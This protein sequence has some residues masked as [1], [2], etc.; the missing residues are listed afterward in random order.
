ME[1]N[2]TLKDWGLGAIPAP[3]INR[4][5][6]RWA[7]PQGDWVKLN[8]DGACRGNPGPAGIGV[9]IRNSSGILLG[10][11]YGS[12]G[13]ATN[14][15]AE[16]RALAAG[17]DLCIQRGLDKI[18]F[19]GESQII[20]N[21]VTKS[22]FPNWKLGKWVHHINKSLESINSFEFKHNY[23]EGN[24]VVDLLANMGIE[25]NIGTIVFSNE[26]ADTM[27]LDTILSER[28]ERQRTGIR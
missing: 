14:N 19:E 11:L 15:E 17:L 16:I 26:D 25:K 24:K 28:P 2:W 1:S 9:V 3:K 8:F 13:L 5:L 27:V 7:P 10:G 21:G 22:N 6:I 18:C 12:L 20:I 23:R 4:K